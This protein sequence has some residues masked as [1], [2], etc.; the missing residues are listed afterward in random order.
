MKR[1]IIVFVLLLAALTA[2]LFAG[3]SKDASVNTIAVFGEGSVSRVPD[4]AVLQLGVENRSPSVKEAFAGN[5]EGM[6]KLKAAVLSFGVK[7]SDITTVNYSVYYQEPPYTDNPQKVTQGTYRVTNGISVIVR[8]TEKLG[9][10]IEAAVAAGANQLWGVNFQV[11]SMESAMEE[12]RDKAIENARKKAEAMAAAAGVKV[13]EVIS[14]A[15]T[16]S[17]GVI[18]MNM[19]SMA[20]ANGYDTVSPGES[21]IRTSVQMVFSI[22]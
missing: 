10:I 14:I 13:D 21:E 16:G 2:P 5:L 17:G 3:G 22:K 1:K 15:E 11:S 20:Y 12:A 9:A 6:K 19:K 4:M 7:E 8:D 18:P